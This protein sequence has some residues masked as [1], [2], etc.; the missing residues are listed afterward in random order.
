MK[1]SSFYYEEEVGKCLVATR[2]N[3]SYPF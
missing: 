2:G 3:L 1:P